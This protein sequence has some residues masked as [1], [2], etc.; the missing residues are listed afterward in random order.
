MVCI[1]NLI[2][3]PSTALKVTKILEN[4]KIICIEHF[5]VKTLKVQHGSQ[6]MWKQNKRKF[7]LFIIDKVLAAFY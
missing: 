5:M 6:L 2:P 7:S 3:H 1:A 4:E